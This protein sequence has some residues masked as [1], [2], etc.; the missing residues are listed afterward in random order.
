[1]I[2]KYTDTYLRC[3]H[4]VQDLGDFLYAVSYYVSSY[5]Y[6]CVHIL[7]YMCPHT[8]ACVSSFCRL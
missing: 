2:Y 6:S 7:L 1:M 8:T 4:L 5:Y 3:A